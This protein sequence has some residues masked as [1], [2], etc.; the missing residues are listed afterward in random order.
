MDGYNPYIVYVISLL[1][2]VAVGAG[3]GLYFSRKT[4]RARDEGGRIALDALDEYLEEK[5]K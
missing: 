3:M 2:A 1:L 4:R 5:M